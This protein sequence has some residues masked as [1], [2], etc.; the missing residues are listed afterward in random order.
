MLE[1]TPEKTAD[2]IDLKQ[3]FLNLWRGKYIIFSLS[4]FAVI[5]SSM[6]LRGAE[7]KYFVQG[8]FKPVVE[9][10]SGPNL[11]GFSGLASLAGVSLPKSSS[12]DFTAYQKLIFSEEVAAKVLTD[13]DLIIELFKT[14]WDTK[15]KTFK[16]GPVNRFDQIKQS[17]KLLVT[18]SEISEYIPP[19][20]QRLSILIGQLLNL[21]TDQATGFLSINTES[22]R[23]LVMVKLILAVS[24]ETDNLLKERFFA[25]SESTLQFYYQKLLTSR[26]PEHREALAQ[27]ISAEDQKLMLASKNSNFVAEPL[28]WPSVSFNPISPNSKFVLVLGV[29]MGFVLGAAIVLIREFI[30]TPKVIR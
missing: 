30:A 16:A 13:Q 12:S 22:S 1:L 7:R 18:G 10:N 15:T 26:S 17:I 25:T 6:Y 4:I 28:T 19:N 5:L 8:L 14:E 3:I 27:L 2:E 21:S 11:S 24:Q 29:V 20:S 23:P 9:G